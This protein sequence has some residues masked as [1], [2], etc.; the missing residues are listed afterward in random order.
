MSTMTTVEYLVPR[1]QLFGRLPPVEHAMYRKGMKVR[2]VEQVEVLGVIIRSYFDRTYRHFCSH[3]QTPSSGVESH[4]G[5]MRNGPCIYFTNPIFTQY[6]D[7]APRWCK[8]L[9]LDALRL[10]LE[11]PLV[12]HNGPSTLNVTV[13]EQRHHDRWIIHLLHFI[14]ERRS[15]KLDVIEDIIPLVDLQVRVRTKQE[16][17]SVMLV[18]EQVPVP[19]DFDG[20]ELRFSLSR[21]DGHGMVAVQF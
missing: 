13:N 4:P 8:I 19:F 16:V 7:N 15:E 11:S 17:A 10:L 6:N 12:S 9:V 18:P 5:V 3:R 21:L 1:P 20:K 2:T 14:P